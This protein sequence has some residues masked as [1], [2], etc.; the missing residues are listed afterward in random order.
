MSRSLL[1]FLPQG[2]NNMGWKFTGRPY[3]GDREDF[4]EVSERL[5]RGYRFFGDQKLFL[6]RGEF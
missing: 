2:A 6:K 5:F 4:S 1:W 3:L